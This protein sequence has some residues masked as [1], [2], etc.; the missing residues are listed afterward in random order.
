MRVLFLGDVVGRS[1]HAAVC[2]RAKV[3]R[4]SLR[5]DLLICNAENAADGTGLT[6][7]QFEALRTAGVDGV[8]MGDHAYRKRELLPLMAEDPHLIRPLNFPDDAVG[9]GWTILRGANGRD[10][11]IFCVM[12]RTFM[13]PVDCPLRAIDRVLSK[14]PSE[15]SARLVDLHAEA[16]S[17]KQL[18]AR[19]VDGR[20]S[21]VLGT[22]THVPTA[23]AEILSRGTAYQ[24]DVGMC[25]PH[26][27]V[28]GRAYAPVLGASLRFE[29]NHYAVAAD[30]IRLNGALV[31]IKDD[32]TAGSIE[33]FHWRDGAESGSAS[34]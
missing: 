31:E 20:V 5:L 29:P 2:K 3:L 11:A 13:R 8:T 17:D 4:E 24:T 26:S 15:V 18:I 25:G 33:P 1:G 6:V 23:D 14:I 7:R 28:I 12:G 9:R 19:Y 27:G 22:H 16:T 34:L 30:D 21:A 10:C 32:G